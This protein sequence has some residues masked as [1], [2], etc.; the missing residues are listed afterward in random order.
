MSQGKLDPKRFERA[1]SDHRSEVAEDY[2]ELI[3]DEIERDGR[4]QL[5]ELA[6]LLGV[7]HPTVAKA[8]RK[9]EDEGLVFVRPYHAV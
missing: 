9:L 5:T 6:A 8:L 2:V 7:T 1:R 3:L 4:A